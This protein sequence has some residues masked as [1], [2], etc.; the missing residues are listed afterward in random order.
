M[1]KF[2]YKLYFA[3]AS[4]YV[5]RSM[6]VTKHYPPTRYSVASHLGFGT[7]VKG[8]TAQIDGARQMGE[9]IRAIQLHRLLRQRHRPRD[10][11]LRVRLRGAGL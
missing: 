5:T 9:R 10:Q 3:Q 4:C 11:R 8:E 1:R 6:L 2:H 7:A